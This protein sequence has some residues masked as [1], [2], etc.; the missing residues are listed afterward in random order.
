M[1]KTKDF[2][3]SFKQ[4]IIDSFDNRNKIKEMDEYSIYIKLKDIDDRIQ[5]RFCLEWIQNMKF[6]KPGYVIE[7]LKVILQLGFAGEFGEIGLLDTKD[8]NDWAYQYGVKWQ[9]KEIQTSRRNQSLRE[10]ARILNRPQNFDYNNP[11]YTNLAEMKKKYGAKYMKK[12]FPNIIALLK[13]ELEIGH[14]VESVP[15]TNRPDPLLE[16][17]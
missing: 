11:N 12:E 1:V 10:A 17:L 2:A 13:G 14:P 15:T 9:S 16:D 4:I 6:K 3:E 5:E 8:F 7:D